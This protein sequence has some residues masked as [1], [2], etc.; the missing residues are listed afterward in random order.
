MKKHWDYGYYEIRGGLIY[1]YTDI[2]EFE[3]V[4]IINRKAKLKNKKNDKYY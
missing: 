1:Y 4:K 2:G 3:R